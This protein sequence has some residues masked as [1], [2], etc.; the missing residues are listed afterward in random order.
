MQLG[1][2]IWQIGRAALACQE[3]IGMG[4]AIQVIKTSGWI[5]LVNI[6]CSTCQGN[7]ALPLV[8][9]DEHGII[10][11]SMHNCAFRP[12]QGAGT[13]LAGDD[14]VAAMDDLQGQPQG[15][16]LS[17]PFIANVEQVKQANECGG[18]AG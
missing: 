13:L 12:A 3:L 9:R 10:G 18:M 11:N 8:L 5:Q 2:E 6:T 17:K 7:D 14:K 1:R 4:G 16:R 15:I